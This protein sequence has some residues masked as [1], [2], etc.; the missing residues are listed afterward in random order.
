MCALWRRRGARPSTSVGHYSVLDLGA[1]VVKALVVERGADQATIV[2]RGQAACGAGIRRDGTIGEIAALQAAC[3]RALTAAEDGTEAIAGTKIVPDAVVIGVPA[4]WLRSASAAMGVRRP[5]LE[6]PITAEECAAV[7]TSAGERAVRLLPHG[8]VTGRWELLDVTVADIRLDG[9]R[10]TD[11]VGFRGH[12]LE[13]IATAFAAPAAQVT[14]L[15]EIAD[16]L[17]LDP[18][19]L[20]PESLA[21][22]GAFSGDGLLIEVGAR[23]TSLALLRMGRPLALG[24]VQA[25]GALLSEALATTFDL[26]PQRAE[27]VLRAYGAGQL[28]ADQAEA[29]RKALAAPLTGWFSSV[30]EVLR[31]WDVP[32]RAWLPDMYLCG[33]T[34]ALEDLRRLLSSAYW[35]DLLPLPRIPTVRTWDGSNLTGLVDRTSP[36]WTPEGV[37][38]VSLAVWPL[39]E[40][41][42]GTF[43]GVL[44][45]SVAIGAQL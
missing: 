37:T 38:S 35:L 27:A 13:V 23:T 28:R 14:A 25:G 26:V 18:P 10:V 16:S 12:T 30:I 29:V 31:S 42:P 15:R 6:E 32:S 2:G 45:S 9:R 21:L 22:C 36:R 33:G 41:G 24:S 7:V 3:D 5:R 4:S 19:L 1:S 34:S 20:V 39:H 17:K 8:A 40:R 43:D 44:R 11:P